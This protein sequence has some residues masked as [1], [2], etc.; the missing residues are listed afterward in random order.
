MGYY[1]ISESGV[2]KVLRKPK[3][4]EEGIAPNTIAVMQPTT[5]KRPQEIWVMYQLFQR[6]GSKSYSKRIISIW[7][8]PGVS[9]IGKA[10]FIPEDTLRELE[11]LK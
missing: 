2:K 6:K 1:G 5:T 4:I 9:P 11:A 8:Y 10:I 3:R 7:R